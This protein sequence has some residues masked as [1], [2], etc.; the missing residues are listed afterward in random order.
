M[1]LTHWLRQLLLFPAAGLCS[2]WPLVAENEMRPR[3]YSGALRQNLVGLIATGTAVARLLA[4]S[5]MIDRRQRGWDF[6]VPRK[7]GESVCS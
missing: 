1:D 3:R 6:A 7:L 5:S 4:Q 2:R